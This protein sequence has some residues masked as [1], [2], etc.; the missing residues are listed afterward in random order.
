[1]EWAKSRARAK[2]WTE[3]VLLLKEEMRRVLCFLE[4]KAEWWEALKDNWEGTALPP[5]TI[6]GMRAYAIS[7]AAL[8]R[9]LSKDFTRLWE[10]PLAETGS[11]N[12]GLQADHIFGDVEVD[13]DEDEEDPA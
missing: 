1:M 6:A 8:Q 5:D 12:D 13:D 3:E 4:W 2:R 9:A 7:Q 11:V 10:D